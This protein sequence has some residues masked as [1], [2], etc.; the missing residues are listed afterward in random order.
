[1]PSA[2]FTLVLLE[3]FLCF[4]CRDFQDRNLE[5]FTLILMLSWCV[6]LHT[7]C[8][9]QATF[10]CIGGSCD[11]HL[12]TA[13]QSLPPPLILQVFLHLCLQLMHR[14][15]HCVRLFLEVGTWTEEKQDVK[16][17]RCS[18]S[19]L[20]SWKGFCAM[21]KKVPHWLDEKWATDWTLFRAWLQ[22][23]LPIQHINNMSF[24]V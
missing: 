19:F 7:E 12:H 15:I 8:V 14:F 6:C 23:K 10:P 22:R 1:M 18:C 20:T 2:S 5:K 11:D 21:K 13:A 24:F 9:E 4:N 3:V 16:K 17:V